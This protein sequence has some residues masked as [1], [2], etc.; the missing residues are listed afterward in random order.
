[1][2]L[3]DIKVIVD[4]MKKN[5]VSEFEL[6]EG[7]F[8]IK[9]KRESG[10]GRKGDK[11]AEAPV[12]VQA[13]MAAPIPAPVPAAVSAV[14]VAV[15]EP[16]PSGLEVKSPMIGTFYRRP[17]P[18]AEPFAEVGAAVEPDTVVAIIEAMKVMNEIKAEVKGAIAEV[19][20]EDG[21][22]VEYGQALFRI[23]PS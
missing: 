19:L 23:E 4:L 8:K 17:S 21:K 11:A 18:D 20:V 14:P 5:A 13:P 2:D 16:A 10:R 3:K 22:P 9:L 1:M 7:D 12:I 6:E 15:P